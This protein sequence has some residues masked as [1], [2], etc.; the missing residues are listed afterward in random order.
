LT[1]RSQHG[2][3]KHHLA[4]LFLML[5]MTSLLGVHN[6]AAQQLLNRQP[7]PDE[8]G[9]RP[10]D[11]TTVEV[12]P[13]SLVWLHEDRAS[14]YTIQLSKNAEMSGAETIQGV[15]YNCYTHNAPL[16]PQ[17]YYWRY[18]V[19]YKDGKV[20]EWSITRSFIVSDNATI[21]PM[22]SREEQRQ[23]VPSEHPR[24]FM[25]PDDVARWHELARG[26]LADKFT[27]IQKVA[28]KL[29]TAQ[30]TPEPTVRASQSDPATRQYWWPNRMQTLKAC[31]EAENLAF[32]YLVTSERKYVE[33]A[34]RWVMHLASW[35]PGGPTNI[36]LND[37][38]AMPILHRLPRAYDW[39]YET[40]TQSEREAVRV[41]MKRR[42]SDA[43]KILQRGPH[44]NK[45]FNS[46][47]N[48][49]WHKLAECAIALYHDVPEAEEW[50]DYAVNI[51]YA[52]YPAWSDDDGG[53]HEGLSYWAGYMSK[54]VWW[55]DV[56]KAALRIDGFKKPFFL[57]VGDYAL[58]T[59]PPG[60]PNMG[61]GDL[62]YGQP[63]RYWRS[64]VEYYAKQA[65]NGYWY[66]WTLQWQGKPEERILGF[67]HATLPPIDPKSP[68]DLPPSKVFEGIGVASL[69][70]TIMDSANDVH[71][72]FKSS[73][74]GSWSHG[75]NPQNSFQL[76]AYSEPLLTTCVYR[77]W[78]GS[79]F[80]TKW[81]W[82]TKAH[83]AILVNEKGQVEHTPAPVGRIT[84]WRLSDSYDYVVGD[85]TA[86]Y[87]GVLK[88]Y[89]R[90]VAFVK[91][92][93]ATSV[94]PSDAAIVLYDDLVAAQPS[95]FQ[96]VLH[97]LSEFSV[98]EEQS[99]LSVKRSKAGVTIQY[100]SPEKLQLSQWSGYDPPP[101]VKFP[102][103]WHVKATSE[104]PREQLG[105]LTVIIPYREGAQIEWHAERYESSTAVAARIQLG[106]RTLF[107]AFK[108]Y[109]VTGA[110]EIAGQ[111]F[112]DEV[113]VKT[114][115]AV[116]TSTMTQT[117]EAATL[118]YQTEITVVLGACVVAIVW[119][120]HRIRLKKA[121]KSKT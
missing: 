84:G 102:N 117:E 27:P 20:S 81:C 26:T 35:D 110:A 24:L 33:A 45:P 42:G 115:D 38:A 15:R 113:N 105:I 57:K 66:W 68:S 30:P 36:V 17:R 99:C 64:F 31:E 112:T 61:F 21:F 100:L 53:W 94:Q 54:A 22:P 78:H 120:V 11:G 75:H 70:L 8:I 85:A 104:K 109:G 12:N 121:R 49:L 114:L 37:E 63:S 16:V 32:T 82:N 106:I 108:K 46:H 92:R 47:N 96:L 97:A 40:L 73:P 65:R 13:P 43:Y 19:S 111:R 93:T 74:R 18:H 25:R 62:S 86:A 103:Q 9:Y 2:Q 116:T 69:H 77:D 95:T 79:P 23:L 41:A 60:S 71:L 48:R 3:C 14:S 6:S 59:A 58:W 119:T 87:D 52:V 72:L 5:T 1:S 83:N 88:R 44:I 34:R 76:N 67:L 80:H 39:A 28:D 50:L 7:K 107:V 29:L 10:A 51:F 55:F 98:D 101:E 91:L 118:T 4:L 90:R 56:A 89:L